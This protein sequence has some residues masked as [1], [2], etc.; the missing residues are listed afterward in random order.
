MANHLRRQIREAAATLLTGLATTGSNV[1]DSR[2]YPVRDGQ[3]PALRIF[4]QSETVEA[5]TIGAGP[6]R[7]QERTLTLTVEG[8]IKATSGFDDTA[9]AICKEVETAIAGDNT[10]G[11]KC[12]WVQ[13]T[14]TEIELDGETEQPIVIVRLNFQVFY[15]TALN[16]PDVA[17]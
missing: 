5:N 16:A 14:S 11:G 10:L 15:I 1:F 12:K 9:D 8:C 7:L 13:L 4:T 17:L 6:A 3:L 2:V